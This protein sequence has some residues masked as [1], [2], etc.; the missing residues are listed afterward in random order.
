MQ[1][2]DSETGYFEDGGVIHRIT[3]EFADGRKTTMIVSRDCHWECLVSLGAAC[4]IAG[5][6]EDKY[7]AFLK[8]RGFETE[9]VT[10]PAEINGTLQARKMVFTNPLYVAEF[11][12]L[13]KGY[14]D[15]CAWFNTIG[16]SDLDSVI[17]FD[18]AM[19]PVE[20]KRAGLL[21]I[22]VDEPTPAAAAPVNPVSIDF[23]ATGG[24]EQL[25]RVIS[26]LDV[27][28]QVRARALSIQND[29]SQ[30]ANVI[31]TLNTTGK[32]A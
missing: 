5:V 4:K 14:G 16:R 26:S 11:I 6:S 32:A 22:P 17:D 27:P 3:V 8:S 10:V 29:F 28:Y 18:G 20:A 9:Y 24:I 1:I 19:N 13:R 30:L 25:N 23:D 31:E 12:K 7:R 21:S 2:I 15:I